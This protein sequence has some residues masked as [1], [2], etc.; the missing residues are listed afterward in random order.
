[1]YIDKE[2][3]QETIKGL[4]PEAEFYE[5]RNQLSLVNVPK[6]MI[7]ELLTLLRDSEAT[8]LDQLVDITAIDW[9]KKRPLRF[10]V[11]YFLYSISNKWRL[12]VKVALHERKP[13]LDSVYGVFESANWYERET[14]DMYGVI[15][16]NHPD[17][18][19][20]YMPEDYVDPESGE[21]I[22][23]MRK[24]FPLMGIPDSMPLPPYPEKYGEVK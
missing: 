9:L 23:P 2:L 7:V 17:F 3:V 10:E 21:P 16:N 15:F 14:Y 13:N 6:E 1:M 19:R 24:D 4:I 12:R 11:V 18:R 22:Y 5:H 20:F 8:K